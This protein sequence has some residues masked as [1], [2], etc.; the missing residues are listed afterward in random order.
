MRTII[1]SSNYFSLSASP[2]KKFKQLKDGFL[3]V[4]GNLENFDKHVRHYFKDCRKVSFLKTILDETLEKSTYEDE[5]GEKH[6]SK[7]IIFCE[8]SPKIKF[9]SRFLN[10]QARIKNINSNAVMLT[11]DSC[12]MTKLRNLRIFKKNYE[13]SNILISEGYSRGID[14]PEINLIINLDIPKS[15]EEYLNRISRI[16][17]TGNSGDIITLVS[18]DLSREEKEVLKSMMDI[19]EASGSRVSESLRQNLTT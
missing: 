13:N 11:N 2:L 4:T 9:I 14:F 8:D 5:E 12:P 19:A 10:L 17:R 6:V 16:S 15:K 1:F 3:K 7:I 18:K